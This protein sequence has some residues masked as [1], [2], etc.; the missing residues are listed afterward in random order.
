V[1]SGWHQCSSQQPARTIVRR[2]KT[3]LAACWRVPLAPVSGDEDREVFEHVMRFASQVF[4]R[5][6]PQALRKSSGVLAGRLFEQCRGYPVLGRC[7][8]V[9][10]VE[11]HGS[12]CLSFALK[13]R[14]A[15]LEIGPAM[16][17]RV[18]S[19]CVS[20]WQS[21]SFRLGPAH[22]HEWTPSNWRCLVA[23]DRSVGTPSRNEKRKGVGASRS[24]TPP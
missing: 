8:S 22:A 16:G 18:S 4:R 11:S 6:R 20:S 9:R 2:V 14:P 5:R 24:R 17:L 23:S 15:D 3:A 12:G 1:R 21:S 7:P 13:D 10:I 19:V